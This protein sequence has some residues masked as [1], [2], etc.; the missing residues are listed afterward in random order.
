MDFDVRLLI[1]LLPILAAAGWAVVN[2]GVVA[3]EEFEKFQNKQ[4]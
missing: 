1:V 4:F 3:M 2:I